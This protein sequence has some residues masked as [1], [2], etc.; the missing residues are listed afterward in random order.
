M[1]PT[2]TRE[3]ETAP[4]L[5][6]VDLGRHFASPGGLVRAAD[7]DAAHRAACWHPQ[8]AVVLAPTIQEAGQ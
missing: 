1:T 7:G 8:D 2:Q 6:L 3:A 5:E 4:V